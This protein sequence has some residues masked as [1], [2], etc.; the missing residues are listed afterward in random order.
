MWKIHS[1]SYLKALDCSLR[2]SK[3]LIFSILGGSVV[4]RTEVG[5]NPH[6][7]LVVPPGAGYLPSLSFSFICNV[8]KLICILL[9]RFDNWKLYDVK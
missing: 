6:Y 8:G 3:N 4:S 7:S 5:R 9:G 2:E 1:E